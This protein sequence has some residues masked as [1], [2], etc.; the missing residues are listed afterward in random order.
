MTDSDR[1]GMDAA[2]TTEVRTV[3]DPKKLTARADSMNLTPS[4]LR[5]VLVMFSGSSPDDLEAALNHIQRVRDM[6]QEMRTADS[7]PAVCADEWQPPHR[8][9]SHPE[10]CRTCS[11]SKPGTA[12]YAAPGMP[13]GAPERAREIA[14]TMP[15]VGQ[16]PGPDTNNAPYPS[17]C[18]KPLCPCGQPDCP[19][20]A[21]GD[22][23]DHD[24]ECLKTGGH[25]SPEAAEQ[26]DAMVSGPNPVG[27]GRG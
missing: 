9:G 14:E 21:F 27:D 10:D 18:E 1:A 2:S 23:H 20:E 8:A 7:A 6:Y 19:V 26:P 11:E 3:A 25:C 4:E 5:D 15:T 22:S 24:A 17:E 16:W 13:A 12:P